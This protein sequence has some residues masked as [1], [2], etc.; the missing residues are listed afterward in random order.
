[1]SLFD[2]MQNVLK[3]YEYEVSA[4]REFLVLKK[5]RNIKLKA[6]VTQE[7][8]LNI[9]EGI[10]AILGSPVYVHTH[11]GYVW[12]RSGEYLA[13]NIFEE[14][15]NYEVIRLYFFNKLPSGQKLKYQDYEQIV[16]AVKEVFAEHNLKSNNFISY[17]DNT[18]IFLGENNNTMCIISIKRRSLSFGY[19][20]KEP[21]S[22]G[23]TRMIPQYTRKKVILSYDPATIGSLIQ[24]CF[25]K[26]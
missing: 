15:Y 5:G 6:Q 3:K 9:F 12:E 4:T 24:S 8:F 23:M 16:G 14:G 21:I 20:K 25:D 22:D 2:I 10:K 26:E 19:S 1:M 18:F 13:Y 17:I 11:Y 7:L